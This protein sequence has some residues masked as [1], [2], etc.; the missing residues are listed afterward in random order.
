MNFPAHIHGHWLDLFNTRSASQIVSAI[1][2]SDG[3]SD[4]MTVV[5]ELKFKL[6]PHT[7]KKFISYRKIRDI[8]IDKLKSDIQESELITN[9]NQTADALYRQYHECII[10]FE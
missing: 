7:A 3:L 9:P 4:H 1:F 10:D 6:R 8:D 2:A 5:A